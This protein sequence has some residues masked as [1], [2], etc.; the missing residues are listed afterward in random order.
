[1]AKRKVEVEMVLDARNYLEEDAKVVA[2]S[3]ATEAALDDMGTS[4]D[5]AGTDLSEMAKNTDKASGST[6]ELDRKTK[7]AADSLRLLDTRIVNSRIEIRRLGDEFERTGDEGIG[8]QLVAQQAIVES[9]VRQR[10]ELIATS[11]KAAEFE[12]RA[13]RSAEALRLLDARIV[14]TRA[15]VHDLGVEFANTGDAST[16]RNLGSQRSLLGQLTTL[17]K[18]L[19]ANAGRTGT[20]AG[21]QFLASLGASFQGAAS[22]PILGPILIGALSVAAAAALPTLGAMIAG[23]VVGGVTLGG[24]AGGIF[25]AKSDPGVQLAWHDFMGTLTGDAFGKQAF[26]KPV[27]DG[28]AELQVGFNSLHIGDALAKGAVA[29]PI[30]AYG[31]SKLANGIMPGFNAVMNRA[32][33]IANTFSDGLGEIGK[34]LGGLLTDVMASKGTMDGLRSIFEG[35]SLA[36]TGVGKTVAFLSS[37]YHELLLENERFT[38]VNSEL[39]AGVPV[40]GDAYAWLHDKILELLGVSQPLP[41]AAAAAGDAA[42]NASH[43]VQTFGDSAEMA[44]YK[45]HGLIGAWDEMT[46]KQSDLDHAMLAASRAVDNVKQVFS[47]GTKATQGH[48]EAVVENRVA[49]EDAARAAAQVADAYLKATGDVAGAQKIMDE[50]KAS[51]EKATGATGGNREAVDQLADSLFKLPPEV[52]VD[53]NVKTT[54]TY[55]GYRVTS[56]QV[57]KVEDQ[58]G[59]AEGG[60]VVAGVPYQ[61]NERGFETVTFPA[62]GTVHPANLTPM[63][64][65]WQ[66]GNQPSGGWQSGSSGGM[67]GTSTVNLA[68]DMRLNGQSVKKMLID[69]ALGRGV[70]PSIISAAYP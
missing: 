41:E 49:L 26:I 57:A 40:L 37:A 17:R 38:K 46:G 60:P 2:A 61:I 36:I 56:A 30:L 55:T 54:Y 19:V 8:K 53:V 11:E 6:S 28:I 69:N 32:E 20:E 15:L 66:A 63:S 9:L 52:N 12:R 25:A 27:M 29:V 50:Y 14:A 23:A 44:A 35:L 67:G 68:V 21:Q 31:I 62:S 65:S 48:S 33:D 18:E 43:G 59:R 1:V 5:G 13:T 24:I 39:Y 7:A 3:K 58:L 42:I 16:G 4:A 10:S 45:L 34:S 64:G 51:A 22:T 70:Q 47:D